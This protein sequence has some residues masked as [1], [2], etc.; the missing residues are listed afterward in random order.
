MNLKRRKRAKKFEFSLIAKKT[1]NLVGNFWSFLLS[2]L[3]CVVWL[4]TGPLFDYSDTWQLIINTSTTVITFLIVFLL[5]NS[6]NRD[7]EILNIKLDELIKAIKKA[8]NQALILDELS[9]AELKE[10]IKEY[11]K[12]KNK[13]TGE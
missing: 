3:F 2:T 8:D 5:Q 6:Q 7:T 10:L 11:K 4:V 1:C 13:V 12:M 9:E